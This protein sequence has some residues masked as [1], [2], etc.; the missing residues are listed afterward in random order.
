MGHNHHCH[1][2]PPPSPTPSPHCEIALGSDEGYI[3]PVTPELFLRN[4]Y[5]NTSLVR[6]EP[7]RDNHTGQRNKGQGSIT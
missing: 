5:T 1:R 3:Q 7:Y 6:C 4:S 2:T